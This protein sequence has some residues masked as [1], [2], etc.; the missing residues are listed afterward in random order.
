MPDRSGRA[1]QTHNSPGID[2]EPQLNIMLDRLRRNFD[3]HLFKKEK[4][5]AGNSPLS[6]V[7]LS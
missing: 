6:Q 5:V 3:H 1:K 4:K 2:K 7:H